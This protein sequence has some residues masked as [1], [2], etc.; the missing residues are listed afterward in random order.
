LATQTRAPSSSGG[1]IPGRDDERMNA[2]NNGGPIYGALKYRNIGPSRGGR[3]VAV[4]GDPVNRSVFYFGSTGGGVWKTTDGGMS[5]R[6]VSDGY[7]QYAS[8]GAL[9]VAPSDPNVI[10]AGMGESSIRGNVSRGDGV[11]KST[12][13]GKS[14]QHMG[15]AETQNI[16]EIVIHPQ[17]PDVVY[18]AAFG[19]VWGENPERGVYRSTNGGASWERML[20]KSDKAGAVD[21]S[22]DPT[23]PRILYASIWEA[24]RGPH[25]LSSGGEDSGLWRTFDGGDSWEDISHNPGLPQGPLG[26]IGVA[27]SGAQAGRVY[28]IV[29]AEDGAVFVSD[30]YGD[31]WT[32]GSEDRNLR[33]RAWYYHH[34]YA[35]PQDENTLWVLNVNLWKSIDAG[36]TFTTVTV[37][38]GDTH[39]LWIDP[40]DPQRMILGDDGGAEVSFQGGVGWSPIL[41]QNT[42]EFY[43]VIVDNRVP[44]RVY[45]A[46][47]DNT[48]MSV[49]SRSNTGG[50]TTPEW[51]DIGGGESGYI[52]IKPDDP[53]IVFSGSYGGLLTRYD[54]RTRLARAV[55]VWPEMTLGSAAADMKYRFQWTSPTVF[56]PHDTDVVYHGGNHV[57]RSNN[58]GQSWDEISPDLTRADPETLGPSG[59]PITK[60][61]TGAETYATVFAIAESPKETGVI[62]AGTDDGMVWV[63][64][65]N[66]GDWTN[67]NPPDLPDWALISIIEASP[68]QPGKAYLAATRY[69]SH[70]D[71]PYLYKTTDYGQ[72][73]TKIVHG[74]P[75]YEFTR[76]IREDPEVEGLLF[77][78]TERGVWVSF[79]DGESW[80]SLKLNLPV[81]PIHDL[82]IAQG[83]LVVGTHG[84]SFW[85]LDDISPLR[86]V[87]RGEASGDAN[88]TL[89]Q[90]GPTRRWGAARGFGRPPQPGRNYRSLGGL[91]TGFEVVTEPD[92]TNK[93]VQ[94]DAG[95]NPEDGVAIRYFFREAPEGEVKITIK[96]AGGGEIRSFSSV[97]DEK[98]EAQKD[99]PVVP[100]KA[101][102][103]RFVWNMRYPDVPKIPDDTGSLGFAGGMPNGPKAVP[104]AYLVELAA[105][106]QTV[107]QT[108]E[109][110]PDPRTGASQADYQ[111]AFDLQTKIHGKISELNTAVNKL[112][113]IRKQVD[114]WIERVKDERVEQAANELKDKLREVEDP[115]IQWRAKSSQDTLNFPVML[116]A[117]LTA[118]GTMVGGAEAKPTKQMHDVYNDLSG[119]VDPQIQRLHE[120]VE[121]DVAAFNALIAETGGSAI[122]LS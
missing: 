105:G 58:Q 65:D 54:A 76:T 17:N 3:V 95:E 55:N 10:Y 22:I 71:Q 50:I 44:Y 32:R 33:Q 36:K 25:F 72:S 102:P 66:G 91:Y 24:G 115:L 83:D 106:G 19:H 67:V 100:A 40:N 52:A 29:E 85:I 92:G 96:D 68:H 114:T 35:D 120:I 86:Q 118:L 90:P 7:F 41:N 62:W 30:N 107:T 116:N 56:S 70:D 1:A 88:L 13:A 5:W 93:T 108:F 11:Y 34:I 75:E 47:Q 42:A 48:T 111:A 39:A 84:R 4:A 119:R 112:R 9:A 49:P 46:Q 122:D 104:G 60:D 63:S 117:K 79:N 28:A 74:I 8:V 89:F 2:T 18:V 15:L 57:F 110:S 31:N 27:A 20:F 81:V 73:W 80:E 37:Q 53:D 51:Y 6:N 77:A 16:G 97:K 109:I 26:K 14:W 64:R 98:D 121:Q 101:G 59:G 113:S 43:H 82:V 69:K 78:G 12:D 103:N 38:H 21:L 45:G 23:N 94:L 61:N 99:E 87:A